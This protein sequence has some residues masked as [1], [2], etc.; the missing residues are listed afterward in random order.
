MAGLPNI[1]SRDPERQP[2]LYSH[3]WHSDG[4]FRPVPESRLLILDL[5]HHA[6]NDAFVYTHQWREYDC[7]RH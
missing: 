3:L 7:K 2:E 5:I 1:R 6:T 4:S